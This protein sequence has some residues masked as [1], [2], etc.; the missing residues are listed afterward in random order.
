MTASRNSSLLRYDLP[1][2]AKESCSTRSQCRRR[3]NAST[4]GIKSTS[5]A[6]SYVY[7]FR[8]ASL[9]LTAS[10]VL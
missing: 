4:S 2:D 3:W 8:Y 9:L 10:P 6:R 7:D 1:S 5:V